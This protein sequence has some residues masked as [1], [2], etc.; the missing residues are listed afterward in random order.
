MSRFLYRLGRSSAR[1]PWRVLGAWLLIA[2]AVFS[3]QAAVGGE[4]TDDFALPGT[5]T[6][7]AVDLLEESF[8]A[9]SGA[10]GQIVFH[11]SDAEALYQKDPKVQLILVRRE[12]SPEDLRG[13]RIAKGIL[14]VK[15]PKTAEA[16]KAEKKIAVKAA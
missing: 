15:L 12:T 5:E 2:V 11:A 16:K 6:Q 3:L 9:Q 10:S 7:A 4:T 13:M 14:T 1:H 8:P